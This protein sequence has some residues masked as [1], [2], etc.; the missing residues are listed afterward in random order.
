MKKPIEECTIVRSLIICRLNKINVA[1]SLVGLNSS[2]QSNLA[3]LLK[4]YPFKILFRLINKLN[5]IFQIY[6][7]INVIFI[8][9]LALCHLT[10]VNKPFLFL[11]L[12]YK[13]VQ[14]IHICLKCWILQMKIASE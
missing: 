3:Y 8:L 12:E 9:M 4:L 7:S 2:L 11:S 6:H 5:D 13:Y 1:Q 10:F 14:L